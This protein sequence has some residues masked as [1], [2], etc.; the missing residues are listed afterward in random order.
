LFTLLLH[1]VTTQAAPQVL[2]P[3]Y[4]LFAHE[5]A[6]IVNDNDPLSQRIAAY[7]R[8]ARNIPPENILHVRFRPGRPGINKT[9]FRRIYR[10][11][12]EAT[13]PGVQAYALTWAAP[14]RV[15]CMS[16]TSAFTFG[17]DR[18][19]CS[20]KQCAR[21]RAS[22]YFHSGSTAPYN[23][24]GIR[25]TMAIAATDFRQARALIDRGV[26]SDN[27]QPPG[28]AWLVSTTD[29]ARNVRAA[30]YP[31]IKEAMKGWLDTRIV[32]TNTLRNIDDILFYFT[33][34]ATVEALDTLRFR[35]GAI[36]D[37]LTSAG[38]QLTTSKQM[39]ALRWLEAGAT[40]S[41]GTVVEPCNLPGKF[42]HP[43]LVMD[44]YGSGRTLIEAYWQSVQQ[45]GEGIFIGEPLAAP[46]D[47][48]KV[49]VRKDHILLTTRNLAP[50]LY[51]VAV[52]N[53]PV[54]PFRVLPGL[55]KVDYH[56]QKFRLP[57][58][59]VDYYR[60]ERLQPES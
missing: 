49:E 39:S 26:T 56:Q 3:R 44:A 22:A 27:T 55:L 6:V 20:K 31:A 2:L 53:R 45:P 28:T 5:L 60:L 43:G 50:G 21:T 7:Y 15:E 54:G 10:Q 35:P 57:K 17:F 41:Y 46:F 30:Y 58:L 11:V 40:G 19:F 37:H 13:P 18:A 16:I 51:Q 33:G 48:Q 9:G 34:R 1:A 36:A 4:R 47:G 52:S 38:G 12:Q 25:P 42:P 32:E 24:F 59:S 14:W 29:R 8:K 23:D